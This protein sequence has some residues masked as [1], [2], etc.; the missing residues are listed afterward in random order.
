VDG[1]RRCSC[2]R[3]EVF[4]ACAIRCAA[5][6][7]DAQL[8]KRIEA[9]LRREGRRGEWLVE[10]AQREA[11]HDLLRLDHLMALRRMLDSMD[12]QACF[13]RL[14][15]AEAE[16]RED[17]V[18]RRMD[19]DSRAAVRGEAAYMARRLGMR[20]T[21]LIR[22]ALRLAESAAD[23]DPAAESICYYFY[24]DD[25]RARLC[26]F[27]NRRVYLRRCIPDPRGRATTLAVIALV[28][29]LGLAFAW[30]IEALVLM[31]YAL[32]LSW[33]VAMELIS[34]I[35][36]R[37]IR[38]RRMLKMQINAVGAAA[39]T[40]VTLPVLLSGEA[41]V[42]EMLAQMEAL[43]CL[44]TDANID[45]LLLGDF[46]DGDQMT[47]AD[48]ER[49]LRMAREGIAALNKRSERMKYYYLHRGR[50]L[51]E[52][53][54]RWMGENRK[55]GAL[56]ALNRLLLDVPEAKQAFDAENGCAE[57]LAGRYRYVVTLDADTCYLSGTLQKLIGAMEH[58]LNR[59]RLVRGE[60]RGHGLLQPNMQLTALADENAY[61]D[62]IY[63]SGGVDAYPVS[64]SDFYQDVCARGC[65]A[66]KGIYDVAAFSAATEDALPDDRIL[67]HDLIEGILADA[68]FVNDVHFY[69]GCPNSLAADLNRS[70]RWTRGDWQLLPVIFGKKL[71]AVD[72]MKL[73]GNLLRSLAAPALAG[74]LI[75]ALWLDAP[76]AFAIGLLCA[77]R[78]PLLHPGA[79]PAW[80]R[81]LLE[82]SLLPL[83]AK[84]MLDAILRT[85]WRLF[86][87]GKKLMAW[88][89]A[90]DAASEGKNLQ[91]PGRIAALLLLPGLLRPFWIPVVLALGALFWI[92]ADWALDLQRQKIGAAEIDARQRAMLEKLA[93][94]TWRFFAENVPLDGCGLPP[95]NVQTDP[96]VGAAMR[97][98][99]TNIGL[100]LLS[101]LSAG[102]LGLLRQEECRLRLERTL[103]TLEKLEKWRGQ[104]YNWYDIRSLAPLRPRYVSAVDSGN[105]A[106]ALLLCAR[107]AQDADQAARFR[108][109]AAQME[110]S[111]LYDAKRMLFRI[112][113]DVENDRLSQSHYDLYASEARL[114][115]YAAMMLG[116]IPVRHWSRLARPTLRLEGGMALASWSGTM[117]EYLMP[118]LLLTSHPKTL[119][120]QSARTAVNVQRRFG[121]RRSR[122]WGVSESGYYAFDMYLNYQYRAF[123]LQSLA[124][125]GEGA[126]EVVAPYASVLALC[127]APAAASENI[128]QMLALGWCDEHGLYEAADYLRAD[129]GAAPRLVKSHMAHHQGMILCAL[130]NALRDNYLTG[131]FMS[132]PQARG[133]QLLLQEKPADALRLR[134]KIVK[135][136]MQRPETREQSLSRSADASRPADVHLLHG[137]DTGA[138]VRADGAAFVRSGDV[139]L[140]R[141]S[142][143]LLNRHEG[144]FVHLRRGDTG[145]KTILGRDGQLIF[146][147]GSAGFT[148]IWKGLE[149]KMQLC[150]S[151]EDGTFYQQLSLHNRTDSA[152][153]LELTGCMAVALAKKRDMQ[154]HAAFQNLFVESRVEDGSMLL[155]RRRPRTGSKVGPAMVY[156]AS[157][158]AAFSFE[159]DLERLL[160]RSGSLGTPGGIAD[161]F[162]GNQGKVLNPCAAIRA[163]LLL[164]A[165]QTRTL[166][167]AL[168]HGEGEVDSERC[169]HAMERS[170]PGRALQLASTQVRGIL[171]HLGL[172]A[173][174]YRILQRAAALLLD[175]RLKGGTGRCGP[176]DARQLWR[177]GVSGE[178][179]ILLMELDDPSQLAQ[180]NALISAH[181]FYRMMGLQT[182]L[183]LINAYGSSYHQPVQ[184]GLENLINASH[185]CSLR[186]VSGGVFVLD[187]QHAD[188]QLTELLRRGA[189][190]VVSGKRE[191]YAQLQQLADDLIPR[192]GTAYAPMRA[193]ASPKPTWRHGNGFGG[194]VEEDYVIHLTPDRLPPAPWSNIM[195]TARFGALMT[196]RGGSFAWRENSRSGR[197]TPFGND[198]LREGW[199]WMLYLADDDR[200]RFVRL[201]PGDLPMTDY[202]VRFAPGAC[203]Y[204][205]AADELAFAS[206]F[207]VADEG[208]HMQLRIENRS[209]ARMRLRLICAVNWLLGT[210]G[211]DGAMLRSWFR[212]G[213]CF[214][215]GSAGVGVLAADGD[216]APGCRYMD[217]GD[218]M[219]PTGL[220]APSSEDGHVLELTIDLP[221]HGVCERSL[222]LGCVAD[223]TSA[224]ALAGSF[225]R[226]HIPMLDGKGFQ[227]MLDALR[228]ETPDD[229]L[230]TLVNG[231]LQAQ[232]LY[233]RIHG[234]TGLYQ[235]GGAYG[236][237]D[238]LQDM[239]PM[240]HYDPA[241]V[242]AHI[243]R[244]AAKQFSAGDVLHWWHEPCSGVRTRI[245]DDLLFLPFVT[246][247]YVQITGD[248][249]ILN[250][251]IPFLAEVPIPEGREDVYADMQPSTEAAS[252][253][254][255]C[256]RAFRRAARMGEH[257]LCRMGSGDW[258]D[259]MNRVGCEGRG[260]SV[261]L[262]QF[263]AATAGEYARIAPSMEDRAWLMGLNE[264]LCAAIEQHGWDG[265]WYLRAY[266]DEG[267][268]LGSSTGTECRIDAISQAWAVLAGLDAQR[269]RT[270][271]NAAWQQLVDER[272]GIIRLL[273]PPFGG[274]SDPGYIAAY[275][276][277][278]RE[279]GAQYT[280]A[281]C[282]MVC[283]LARM[284]D[285]RAHDALRMLLPIYHSADPDKAQVYRVEPYVMAADVYS[286]AEHIGRGGWTWYTGSAAWMLMA[287]LELLGY[288]RSGKNVRLNA[289]LG[290]WRSVAVRLR[291]GRSEYRLV[292]MAEARAVTLDGL[293]VE[294]ESIELRDD[295]RVH[296][297]IFPPR[298]TDGAY[299]GTERK[300]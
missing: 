106:A 297:A 82:L 221:A 87:S 70:H 229:G 47:E 121:R 215:S 26:A 115:S 56:L 260:E 178:L 92:G 15:R 83:R 117:F 134:R 159:T 266:T 157:G 109:L 222:L 256:M 132:I 90:A 206:E 102:R 93:G 231:F 278:V 173:R 228:F 81:A 177:I 258:N 191:L 250:E 14:S 197:I 156:L 99:P 162:G 37:M 67:S 7:G 35:Y 188:R 24:T 238:Q 110:L 64:V 17:G 50:R 154:A 114:L 72:R 4:W 262:S 66:G 45:Y 182:D 164:E 21:A 42:H 293:I 286:D 263:L 43:G 211:T 216:A 6:R 49:I 204:S 111:A 74:L 217:F 60:R 73:L 160:G 139:Q 276:P 174:R 85:L 283:A 147:G 8:R 94:Q 166:H 59:P 185:L 279:N 187:A 100:Y 68:G 202:L 208:L 224:E 141:F 200:R 181:G 199:G 36:P 287:L 175:G 112:G 210:D 201:L 152:M 170:A 163:E 292:C 3:P 240:I 96:P 168:L 71:A 118:E 13:E 38:P 48:D 212:H 151:P 214:A 113:A 108:A 129:S 77:F 288:K 180:A 88:V 273:T 52:P 84:T 272:H 244:C 10:Q 46:R 150:I 269:S 142:G 57:L 97:T 225:Q 282:W 257:G 259:G 264:Q 237:R 16:L 230:N 194:F 153:P 243:L 249:A 192:S 78:E 190:I 289:L 58:P 290:D 122:P 209:G 19:D 31:I 239:L 254:Q 294:E 128:R 251:S 86:V 55:R 165:G 218:L 189:A 267:E 207:R 53:D 172:D 291:Y 125:S 136:R 220:D 193:V 179:P 22:A 271:M 104:L 33:V 226:G 245:S 253:H 236:F 63:G 32:P 161:E 20:E 137:A 138:V 235:P 296:T 62:R 126:Q 274:E 140:N 127:C 195:A 91:L 255:H 101:C 300:R 131:N 44:E 123:G 12:W 39:R 41:R 205:G 227:T 107:V 223:L 268:K 9:E 169:S 146:D 23:G 105:L 34:R 233:A 248:S 203:S 30:A 184:D 69:D 130:C 281:A 270:A 144:M 76:Q 145:E 167:F 54:G 40:L 61:V 284:N 95:D 277:G 5:E 261:W 155:L 149:M 1:G 232:I 158:E 65:F 246:A 219:N 285:V 295:G 29:L 234:R 116:Q 25:G 18:Y 51:R 103:Q 124:L 198:S 11:A 298:T 89:T 133:L 247:Q 27:L 280:H 176:A 213:A 28:L 171:R 265:Q 119:A 183:V 2:S 79:A 135:R 80:Q 75:H 148:R 252:L 196:D 143:D 275:P 98:S 299:D 186:N 241:L 242:R 120:G